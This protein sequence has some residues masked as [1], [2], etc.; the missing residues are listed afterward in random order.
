MTKLE[1]LE[2]K[3]F[4]ANAMVRAWVKA[5]F[6]AEFK[7]E[8][9]AAIAKADFLDAEVKAEVSRIEGEIKYLKEKDN[10]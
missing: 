2:T 8:V 5:E 10:E 6:K 7:A 1:R 4:V 9:E 3:L